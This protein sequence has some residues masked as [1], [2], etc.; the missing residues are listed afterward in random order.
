MHNFK[1]VQK[2]FILKHNVIILNYPLIWYAF[3]CIIRFILKHYCL[4]KHT[5]FLKFL[6][7]RYLNNHFHRNLLFPYMHKTFANSGLLGT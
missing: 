3:N 1:N 2:R 7:V 4:L 6:I 5:R